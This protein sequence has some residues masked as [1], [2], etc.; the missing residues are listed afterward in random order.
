MKVAVIGGGIAGLRTAQL[1]ERKGYEVQVFEARVRIGGRLHTV[2]V[3]DGFY[4][5]G[6]EWID[7]D[8]DRVFALLAEFGLAPEKSDER[9][10][11]LHFCGQDAWSD[12]GWPLAEQATKA[13]WET[14]PKIKN[15]QT[16]FESLDD[17][18][19]FECEDDV[20]RAYCE[21]VA[22][23]DEGT[24]SDRVDAKTWAEFYDVYEARSDENDEMSAFRF[25]GGAEM[26][27]KMMA[28]SL[29]LPVRLEHEL[30]TVERV[31][32]GVRLEFGNKHTH[33]CDA[34]VLALPPTCLNGIALPLTTK[35]WAAFEMSPT[36][37]VVLEFS[38]PFW[39]DS[40]WG[41]HLMSD[42]VV[43]QVWPGGRGGLHSLTCYINGRGASTVG[44]ER[45]PVGA[46]LD[47]L[48]QLFPEAKDLFI[49]GRVHDWSKERFSGGGFPV[50]PP[51][52][53][54]RT[55]PADQDAKIF[56]AGDWTA[57]WMG[58]VEGALESAA[59][60]VEEIASG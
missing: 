13:L 30:T 41:G 35:H 49:I 6:G 42:L 15:G 57:R 34:C 20:S 22:L 19:D 12:D 5:A 50:I 44:E 25:P 28:D 59:R 11:R 4:E 51:E 29:S 47:S 24:D 48:A 16:P 9:P 56:F 55:S 32:S 23:S 14:V 31:E 39:E 40:G 10:R 8:H 26:L 3:G 45:D 33:E 17:V 58:F 36:C 2:Q 46:C 53:T 37:K 54:S 1:L 21:A 52:K 43:Q 60:V 38:R 7:A 18:L 27:C